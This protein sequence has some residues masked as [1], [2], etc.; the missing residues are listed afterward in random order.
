MSL[1][2]FVEP[3]GGGGGGISRLL[4][5]ILPPL[6]IRMALIVVM[7]PLSTHTD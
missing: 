7:I 3:N 5:V 2:G 1:A 4:F 6:A